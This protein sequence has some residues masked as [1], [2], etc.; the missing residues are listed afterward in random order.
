MDALRCPRRLVATIAA[1]GL[2]ATTLALFAPKRAAAL[3][4][5][6]TMT[7]HPLDRVVAGANR[8]FALSGAEVLTFDGDGRTLERCAGFAA[9]P[10]NARRAPIGGPDA[11]EVLRAAGLPDDDST[12]EA[13]EALEDEGLGPGRRKQPPPDAGI[14]PRDLAAIEAADVVWIATSSGIFRGDEHG[15]LPG[16]LDGRDLLLVAAAGGAVV[17]ATDDL[18]FR[19]AG[20]RA[21]DVGDEADRD[22][23]GDT[24]DATFTVVAGLTERPRALALGADG[25]AIVADDEGVLVIGGDGES[26]RILDRPTDALAICGGVAIALTD[27]GVYRWTPGG[28]PVRTS[29]RPPIRGLACGPTREARWIAT[30]LGVWTSPDGTIWTERSETLGRRV[31]GAATVGNRIWLAIDN[32]LVALDPTAPEPGL[33]GRSRGPASIPAVAAAAGFAPLPTRHLAAPTFPWPEV[34]ALF[35]VVRTPDRRSWQVMLLLTVPF[36]R[37][38]GRHL[39]PTAVAAER[40]RRDEALGREQIDLLAGPRDDDDDVDDGERDARLDSIRQE[41][42]ALR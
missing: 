24:D 26:E 33:S 19:R 7:S 18:L 36:G 8:L 42:E 4:A 28:L 29:D 37:V 41:R 2:A 20:G 22:T 1:A 14:V 35:G 15:C 6:Q 16:G 17:A 21:T 12:P 27:D 32:G 31:A 25:A 10:Q 30:G 38:A 13:E 40:A 39:D 3:E 34:T 9:P 5:A 11:D 23:D